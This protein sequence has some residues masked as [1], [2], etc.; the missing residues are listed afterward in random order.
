MPMVLTSVVMA[1]IIAI[2]IGS[3]VELNRQEAERRP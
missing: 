3:F 2:G 1:V